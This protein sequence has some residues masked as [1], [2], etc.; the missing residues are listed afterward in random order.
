MKEILEK[1]KIGYPEYTF[2]PQQRGHHHSRFFVT[3]NGISIG[4]FNFKHDKFTHTKWYKPSDYEYEAGV[5]D[6]FYTFQLYLSKGIKLNNFNHLVPIAKA[7]KQEHINSIKKWRLENPKPLKPNGQKNS[8]PR[9]KTNWMKEFRKL[10]GSEINKYYTK[11][12]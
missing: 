10:V 4:R 2:S 7:N 8:R 5:D 1:L 9:I 6:F 11:T 12:V 3:Y